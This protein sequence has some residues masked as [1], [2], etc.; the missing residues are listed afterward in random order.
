M[1]LLGFLLPGASARETDAVR[2]EPP[3]VA[4]EPA[5]VS[6]ESQWRGFTPIGGVSKSGVR[7]TEATALSL[8][9]TLQALR[10]ISGVFAMA[11]LHL[12]RKTEGGRDRM[13]D[14]PAGVLLSQRPN[15]FQS[16]FDLW[17]MVMSD[18]LMA[19]NFYAY[20]SRD[21]R[22]DPIALTRL[23]PGS[24]IVAE[25]FDRAEGQVLFYD[26]TLPDGSRE[27]FAAR[28][29]WHIR[30]MSRD[31]MVGL[32]PVQYAR[33][34]LGGAIATGDHANRFWQKGGRPSTVL[35]T[36]QKVGPDDKKRIRDD[37]SKLY[38]G[39]DASAIAVLDQDLKAAFLSH[40]L[41]DDQFIETRQFQV[42]D[43]ARI[44]GVPPH[45]IFDLSKATFSNIEQQSLEFVTYHLGPHFARVA[46]AATRQFGGAGLYFEH[47]TDALVRGDLKSRMEAYWLQRQMG[48]ANADELR[49]R[50]N[51]NNIGGAAGSEYW[52]PS[53]MGLAGQPVSAAPGGGNQGNSNAQ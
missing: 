16:P 26:A 24:V 35:T 37:W 6:S 32:S 3:V 52:R 41:K 19:G 20:V 46:G 47:I 12:Y 2:V 25:Y 8:P 11:P 7:V 5:K 38:S 17:E 21:F 22:G 28:D 27:R 49:S 50:E 10:I 14:H 18:L 36:E 42:V 48:L 30:G 45:L 4:A 34:A 29:I 44:W 15:S 31:G 51:L 43:L 39:A 13:D 9:A 23:K 53:N 1:G 33:D 40:N